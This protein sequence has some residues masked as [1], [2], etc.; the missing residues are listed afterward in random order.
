MDLNIE[1]TDCHKC[2]ELTPKIMGDSI[3][4][5]CDK[6]QKI[7]ATEHYKTE[8]KMYLKNIEN[9][10]LTKDEILVLT[11]AFNAREFGGNANAEN[12]MHIARS[13]ALKILNEIRPDAL[14]IKGLRIRASLF[15]KI[16]ESVSRKCHNH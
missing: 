2:E 9:L 16:Y 4:P 8:K 14:S 11:M 5:T 15:Y 6:C 1:Y 10:N 7:Q 12:Y 3:F 13:Y